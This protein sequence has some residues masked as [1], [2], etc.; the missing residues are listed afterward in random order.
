MAFD[1]TIEEFNVLTGVDLSFEHFVF[2]GQALIDSYL[3]V[4][5]MFYESNEFRWPSPPDGSIPV[6]TS[7]FR[8]TCPILFPIR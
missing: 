5:K 6:V 1:I 3:I 4:P 8:T 7:K 2:T